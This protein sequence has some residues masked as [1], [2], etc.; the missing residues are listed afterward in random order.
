ML[1]QFCAPTFATSMV[2]QC[3]Q[4]RES[5]VEYMRCLDRKIESLKNAIKLWGNNKII[6][7]EEMTKI[8]GRKAALKGF[9]KSQKSFAIYAEQNCRW[10]YI[11]LLPDTTSSAI[12]FKECT[13]EMSEARVIE[14][15]QIA[16]SS[17]D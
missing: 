15:K 9:K 7:L 13:V 12:K 8:T 1:V 16:N 10:Q 4:H 2:Q 17:K 3:A 14:L 5:S 6:E 11:A